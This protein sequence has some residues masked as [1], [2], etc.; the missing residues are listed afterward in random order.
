MLGVPYAD[1][2]FFQEHTVE[3]VKQSTPPEERRAATRAIQS[4]MADLSVPA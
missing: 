4:Y 2:E 3:V 1:H